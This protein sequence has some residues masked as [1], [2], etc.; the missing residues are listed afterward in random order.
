MARPAIKLA[1][2]WIWT[3]PF[4]WTASVAS[5]LRLRRPDGY[6]VDFFQGRGWSPAC[7]H[8]HACEQAMAWGADLLV[9]LG[10]DQV[11]HPDL[12]E[13]LV[14]RREAGAEVVAA[15][16]PMRGYIPDQRMRP[17]Q[18][19][20]WRLKG[21][22]LRP[23]TWDRQSLQ[24]I[25]PQAGDLQRIDFIGSGCIMFSRAHLEAMARPWFFETINPTTQQRTACMD[26]KFCWR[27]ASDAGAQVWVDTTIEIRHLHAFEIDETFSD[28][29][30]D[31][32]QPGIGDPQICRF[33]EVKSEI[34]QTA[35]S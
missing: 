25:D 16:V 17:F 21:D 14:A 28:R 32:A 12:L 3:S 9:I 11:Y 29:F 2:C 35:A 10:A 33:P 26:T 5:M 22:G 30:A 7:R 24:P 31:W 18:R 34:P 15:L 20:A 19:M 27:L 1:V 6:E 8:N 23:I 4:V 13:R